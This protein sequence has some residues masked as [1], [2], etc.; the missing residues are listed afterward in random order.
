[1]LAKVKSF[2]TLSWEQILDMYN[3]FCRDFIKELA[4]SGRYFKVESKDTN[5][6]YQYICN[7]TNET[8][9]GKTCYGIRFKSEWV[10]LIEIKEVKENDKT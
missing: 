8:C 5:G 9:Y 6:F 10:D 1:M 7:D 2:D 4:K 3:H